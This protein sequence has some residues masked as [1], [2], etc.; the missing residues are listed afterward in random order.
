MTRLVPMT[1]VA[2]KL[3][4]E[5]SAMLEGDCLQSAETFV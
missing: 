4:M 2:L 3:T 5:V 1:I